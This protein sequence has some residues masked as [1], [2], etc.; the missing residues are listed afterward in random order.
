MDRVRPK[1]EKI[2]IFEVYQD[3]EGKWDL[4]MFDSRYSHWHTIWKYCQEHGIEYDDVRENW[5]AI[6]HHCCE[7]RGI[8][9]QEVWTAFLGGKLGEFLEAT[10]TIEPVV[11]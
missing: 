8:E 7:K 2:A 3:A 4:R 11:A 10:K 6:W 9:F 5:C 1:F